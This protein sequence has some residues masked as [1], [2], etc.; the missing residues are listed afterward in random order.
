MTGLIGNE[1]GYVGKGCGEDRLGLGD[2]E[3][4]VPHLNRHLTLPHD[5]RGK[6]RGSRDLKAGSISLSDEDSD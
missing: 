2:L 6:N 5:I 4:V 3:R 1:L